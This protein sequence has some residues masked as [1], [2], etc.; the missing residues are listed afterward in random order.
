ME[1]RGGADEGGHFPGVRRRDDESGRPLP[2]P[3][4]GLAGGQPGR[5]GGWIINRGQED[6]WRP[7]PKA[8]NIP[9]EAP[10]RP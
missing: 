3:P 8:T 4:A 6:E 10:A 7:A 5:G 1:R 9:V 2:D